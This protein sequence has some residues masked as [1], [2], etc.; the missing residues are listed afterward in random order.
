MNSH[1][2]EPVGRTKELNM[3]AIVDRVFKLIL[4]GIGAS[5]IK[6]VINENEETESSV[7]FVISDKVGRFR[8]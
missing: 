8:L 4:N 5:N 7:V 2:Q 3:E 6:H 1:L